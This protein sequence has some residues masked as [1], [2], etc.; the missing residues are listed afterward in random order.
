MIFMKKQIKLLLHKFQSIRWKLP[1]S[2]AGIALLTTVVLGG[3]LL[4][5]LNDYYNQREQEYLEQNA[6]ALQPFLEAVW[7]DGGNVAE[8]SPV[9]DQ[10]SFFSD[11]R[12]RLFDANEVEIIDTGYQVD[13]H[14]LTV[15]LAQPYLDNQRIMGPLPADAYPSDTQD[16]L[17]LSNA[18][19]IFDGI[20]SFSDPQ[21]VSFLTVDTVTPESIVL[22]GS[23]G[24]LFPDPRPNTV[25]EVADQPVLVGQR[26][27]FFLERRAYGGY[28]FDSERNSRA[29]RSDI[30]YSDQ[31]YRLAIHDKNNEVLG[32][33][34]LAGGPALGTTIIENVQT[35]LLGAGLIAILLAA[36]VG[37]IGSRN[38]SQPLQMMAL[39]TE[40]MAEGDHSTRVQLSRR[41]ELGILADSFNH[42]AER[43]ELTIAT[44]QRFVADAAHEIQTPITAIQTNLELAEGDATD[45]EQF[46]EQAQTQLTRLSHLTQNLLNLARLESHELSLNIADVDIGALLRQ[47]SEGYASRAEQL[48]IDFRLDVPD[49]VVSMQADEAQIARVMDNLLDNS[50]KFTP[51][52]GQVTV[53]LIDKRT[54]LEILVKDT[55]IGIPEDDQPHLFNRFTRGH[56]A[57]T[58]PGSGLGLVLAK[59]IVEEHNGTIHF[60]SNAEG[61]CF[62]IQLSHHAIEDD[63]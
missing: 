43:V 49:Q 54:S 23:K 10:F 41:D 38:L 39:A 14:Q 53:Q 17:D 44:L 15:N 51:A 20:T 16:V 26:F 57:T 33:V 42:M 37:W 62:M 4:W 46:V 63:D 6:T 24:N 8:L 61:T 29:K 11:T 45:Y 34:E 3:V 52:R 50:L 25:W 56:N 18:D 40:R 47:V 27:P 60:T 58:Y 5:G 13:R 32:Y 59:T 35:S 2:Y 55:G 19:I 30:P 36:L 9:L 31:T 28:G 7:N 1:L 48:D 22:N 12:L 21:L